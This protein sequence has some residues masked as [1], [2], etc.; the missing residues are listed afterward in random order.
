V[1]LVQ[2]DLGSHVL[3]RAAEG[4][5]LPANLKTWQ[6]RLCPN[7]ALNGI[8]NP[9]LFKTLVS[10]GRNHKNMSISNSF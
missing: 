8:I 6:M 7:A 10:L 4:P 9:T 3:R 2:D 1:P 5:G